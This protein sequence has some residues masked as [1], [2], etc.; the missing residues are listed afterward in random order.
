M[1]WALLLLPLPLLMRRLPPYREAQN[2]VRVPFFERLL[3]ASEARRERGAMIPARRQS[4]RILVVLMW[5]A[6]VLG[7]AKP[8]WVGDP[9]E[10]QKAGRDL[11]IAVDLSGS[12][13]TQDFDN[14]DGEQVDRLTAVKTVLTRLASERPGD[15]LG[16]IVFGNQAFLQSPFTEDHK[17]WATLLE[18][19]R[20][21]MAGPSTALGD[22]VGLA[23]KLFVDADTENRVLLVLTDGNDT[24]SMVPP[25][26]AARV[27]ASEDIRIYPIAVGDPSAVG[28][29]AIDKDTLLR[30]AEVTGGQAFEALDRE[31]LDQIF[32]L[33]DTLEPSVF[34]SVTFRPQVDLYWL[35]LTVL[36][37][38]YIALRLFFGVA[39]FS[40]WKE[41][42][43]Q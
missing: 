3:E 13:E 36:V 14:Q 32:R 38:L 10:Q 30:M 31:Q 11:M 16:L 15:R 40:S 5:L 17:T 41:S 25:V 19:T 33:L 7:V 6:L 18:E 42:I 21:R 37:F 4:Q 35:P 27:A 28:E 34:D 9:I 2:A 39:A 23:I 24:G 43:E 12:M 8:Q 1:P 22:A 29:E 20:I 26:D